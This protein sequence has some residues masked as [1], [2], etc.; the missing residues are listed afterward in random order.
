MQSELST[1][2]ELTGGAEV[3]CRRHPRVE[4]ED[5]DVK[6]PLYVVS[7][8]VCEC[9]GKILCVNFVCACMH[10]CICVCVCVCMQEGQ[11]YSIM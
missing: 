4:E 3:L 8:C 9:V 11:H 7:M 5:G 1:S 6:L 10:S 2:Q